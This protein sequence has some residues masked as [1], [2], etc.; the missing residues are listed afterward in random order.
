VIDERDMLRDSCYQTWQ[1]RTV[2]AVSKAVIVA[3]GPPSAI[4]LLSPPPA[5]QTDS[6]EKLPMSTKSGEERCDYCGS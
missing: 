4:Q 5:I 3:Q 6:P 1:T 2:P